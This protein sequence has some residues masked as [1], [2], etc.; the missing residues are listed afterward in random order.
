MSD[1]KTPVP[2]GDGVYDAPDCSAVLAD[3]WLL[4]DNECD[5]EARARLQEH[6]KACPSCLE[7]YDVQQQLKALIGRK[8]GGE[9]APAGLADRL[10]VEIR[11]SVTIRQTTIHIDPDS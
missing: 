5:Q 1:D 10:R 7:H 8:C 2:D 9:K 4:L 6:I 3:L 11:R